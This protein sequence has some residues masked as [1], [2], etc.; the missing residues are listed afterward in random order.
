MAGL[1]AP[2]P[3]CQ[4]VWGTSKAAGAAFEFIH[5][6]LGCEVGPEP[7]VLPPSWGRL[8]SVALLTAQQPLT[9]RES[10]QK[11]PLFQ[12]ASWDFSVT[13]CARSGVLA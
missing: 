1:L 4:H 2:R 6:G 11:P 13:W 3:L 8:F 7:D 9:V 10:A 12:A 5:R